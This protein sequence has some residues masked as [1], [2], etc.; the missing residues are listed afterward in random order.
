MAVFS[1]DNSNV[2]ILL[3]VLVNELAYYGQQN[4][5]VSFRRKVQSLHRRI[6]S[7]GNGLDS[8]RLFNE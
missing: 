7:P 5:F 8:N 3:P 4:I 6:G 1:L 2:L